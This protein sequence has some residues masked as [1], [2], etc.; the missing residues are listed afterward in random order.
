MIDKLEVLNAELKKLADKYEVG[1]A[2]IP[3]CWHSSYA[4]CPVFD[5]WIPDWGADCCL[6]KLCD[7]VDEI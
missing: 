3:V 1:P 4:A 6:R 7:A 5:I 2:Q